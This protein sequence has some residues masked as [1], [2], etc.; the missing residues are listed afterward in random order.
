MLLS[1]LWCSQGKENGRED[2]TASLKAFEMSNEVYIIT[3][4]TIFGQNTEFRDNHI[5]LSM[6]CIF[7]SE[8]G[9]K[10]RNLTLRP[11]E[12]FLKTLSPPP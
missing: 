3:I 8:F 7:S 4:F 5:L 10:Y 11:T 6:I 1:I 9:L 2:R 12:K